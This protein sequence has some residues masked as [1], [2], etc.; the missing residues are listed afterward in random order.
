MPTMSGMQLFEHVRENEPA[1][2]ARF[3]FATRGATQKSVEQFLASI[4]N[5]V[6]EKPFEMR[7]LRELVADL[8]RAS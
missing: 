6:L 3:V 4:P 5:L 7:V 8:V 2:A 1:L